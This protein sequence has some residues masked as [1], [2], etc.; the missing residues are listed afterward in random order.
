MT[1]LQALHKHVRPGHNERLNG[2]SSAWLGKKWTFRAQR[3]RTTQQHLRV[4]KAPIGGWPKD[5][6]M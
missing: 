6:R 1:G 2:A 3:A 5:E 4:G